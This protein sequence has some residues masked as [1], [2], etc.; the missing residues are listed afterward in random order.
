MATV[1]HSL[2]VSGSRRTDGT[3]NAGGR[4]FLTRPGTANT[5]VTG[6]QDKDKSAAHTLVSGGYLLDAAGKIGIFVDEPCTVRIEDQ[7][8]ITVDQFST[9]PTVSAGLV[10][11]I[12]SGYTGIDPDTGQYVAGERTYLSRILSSFASSVGGVDGKFLANGNATGRYLKDAISDF[13]VSVKTFGA[14][15]N[16]VADDTVPIQNT[17]NFVRSLGG[18]TVLFPPGGYKI[19]SPIT[20]P[21]GTISFVG[22]SLTTSIISNANLAANAFTA[23]S[24]TS[25]AWRNLAITG[26][27]GTSTGSAIALGT[28]TE[29]VFENVEIS[30]HTKGISGGGAGSVYLS[31]VTIPSNVATGLDLTGA[32]FDVTIIGGSYTTSTISIAIGSTSKA[33]II[34]TTVS[35]GTAGIDIQ[36]TASLYA[37]GVI[38]TGVS[39]GLRTSA[40]AGAVFHAACNWGTLGVTD[41]RTGAPV[42]YTFA[43]D[44]NFTPLPSQADEIRVTVTAAAVVTVNNITAIG[45]GRPF[46]L[47]CSRSTAGAVTWTFDTKYVLSAA[48]APANGNRVNLLLLYSPIDDKTYEVGRAATAN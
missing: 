10:E 20:V 12:N 2:A 18:G 7:D 21:S 34:G 33:K 31:N 11:V 13:G 27:G 24:G 47:I 25:H 4:I 43:A 36:S 45:A 29:V 48:V 44:G 8:G 19:T 17:V 6:Y 42:A 26:S 22:Q 5:R 38:N 39:V 37:Y 40:T 15:G 1:I 28:S 9:E 32:A 3:V 23:T 46:T 16:G 35:S 41:Q 14:V 30:S